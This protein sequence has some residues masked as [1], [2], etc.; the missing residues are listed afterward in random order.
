MTVALGTLIKNQ[1]QQLGIPQKN[2]ALLCNVSRQC[3]GHIESGKTTK[4]DLSVLKKLYDYLDLSI[5]FFDFLALAGYR[6]PSEANELGEII[7]KFRLKQGLSD[8]E[9]ARKCNITTPTLTCIEKGQ[10][11]KPSQGIL[12]LLYETLELPMDFFNFLTLGGYCQTFD[13]D[14][15]LAHTI[16]NF[17]LIQGLSKRDLACKC[18]I[19]ISTLI[20]IENGQTKQPSKNILKE[21]YENLVLYLYLDFHEFLKM[22]GYDNESMQWGNIIF[23]ERLRHKL[24]Q[25]ELSMLSNVPLKDL[26]YIE[27]GYINPSISIIEA[28]AIPLEINLE[29]F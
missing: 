19:A 12:K 14:D 10:T 6:K 11:K 27:M 22:G 8:I 5:D 24:T 29:H 7:Y 1:R 15:N 20:C 3:L 16:Y 26:H 4:P 17:R 13:T 21:L 9:L 23:Q 28:L 25:E 18:H 2:L